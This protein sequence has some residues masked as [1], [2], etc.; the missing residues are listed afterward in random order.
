MRVGDT[1]FRTVWIG[2]DPGVVKIIDQRRLP[3]AFE[4]EDLSNVDEV[5]TAIR[6]MHVRGAGCIGATAG[7]GMYLAAREA[8]LA[9]DFDQRVRERAAQLV[10]TRPTAVNLRWAIERQL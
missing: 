6:D 4:V 1:H 7:Y 3:F 5:A 9:A 2:D 10:E 8:S